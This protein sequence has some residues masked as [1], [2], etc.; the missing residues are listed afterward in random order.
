MDACRRWS[1][2]VLVLSAAIVS[3]TGAAQGL[4][5]PPGGFGQVS[6]RAEP[7]AGVAPLT[8]QFHAAD[9]MIIG[10]GTPLLWHFG[11]GHMSR[12]QNPSHTYTAAGSYTVVAMSPTSIVWV[13]HVEVL[14]PSEQFSGVCFVTDYGATGDGV[15]DDT[16]AFQAA[17]DAAATTGGAVLVPPVGGGQGYVLTDTVIVKPG[18]SLVGNLSGFGSNGWS[19]YSLPDSNVKGAKIFARPSQMRKPLF[20]LEGGVTVRGFW[21]LYDQQPWP[22]DQDFANP[23]SPFHYDSLEEARQHFVADCVKPYGPT[24]YVTWGDNT[25]LEDIL[26]DRYYDFFY[27]KAGAKVSVDRISLYGY[28]RGFVIETAQDVNRL[29][30]IELVPNVGPVCPGTNCYGSDEHGI[31]VDM[32]SY[33]WLYGIIIAQRD[34]IG[35]QIGRSDGYTLS[36]LYFVCVHTGLQLGASTDWP[37]YDP[38]EGKVVTQPDGGVGPWGAMSDI[39]IDGCNVG[40]RFVWP[41]G[42]A[43]HITNLLVYPQFDEGDHFAAATGTGNLTGVARHAAIIVEKTY[44]GENDFGSVPAILVSN[45]EVGSSWPE[46]ANIAGIA[47]SMCTANGRV[48]LVA[49]EANI[50]ISNFA[51]ALDV[52]PAA[53]LGVD[54]TDLLI[55]TAAGAGDVSVRVRGF[56][57]NGTPQL[58]LALT[59][60]GAAP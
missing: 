18:V 7:S 48:F 21:I 43:T 51:L 22:S 15:H 52:G 8:V 1:L 39:G 32:R 26:C 44:V 17:I 24:F 29:S 35:V 34:N 2:A 49:G 57:L 23:R 37:I 47:A 40:L 42:I 30:N 54:P 27:L 5:D 38:V 60:D 25:C 36:N 45:A 4:D 56:I 13:G 12:E 19:A 58:D 46:N 14:K 33:G 9:T 16:A 50:E 41:G 28:K 6:F 53:C 55:A 10:G 20:Q 3:M 31:C 59:K 11:D